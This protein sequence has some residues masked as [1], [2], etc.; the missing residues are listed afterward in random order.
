MSGAIAVR[1][2]S[3][4][5]ATI[6]ELD[7]SLIPHGHREGHLIF[8]LDGASASVNASGNDYTVDVDSAVAVSPWEPHSFNIDS[9]INGP[10]L[11]L[12]LYIKPIWFL[13]TSQRAEFSLSFGRSDIIM[14]DQIRQWVH[15]LTGQMLNEESD[16]LFNGYLFEITSQCYQQSWSGRRR[17]SVLNSMR[18]RFS[19]YRV[20]RS[21]QLMQDNFTTTMEMDSLAR[22]VGLSRPHFFKL[23]KKQMGVTPN[24]YLNTLRSEK[25]IE[26][27]MTT[28][29]T[30]S[31]IGFDLGF[32]SQ[33]SFTRFFASNV[34]IPPS[35][36]RRV[37]NAGT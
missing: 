8:Y 16:S 15:R 3:F 23:F 20:R 10:M 32:S 28:E 13:E 9:S 24:L 1:H 17:S 19:D 14:T 34:G 29:K 7:K 6:Y 27:L 2:G 18:S 21:L 4:G 12:T 35:D 5:R 30:V 31:D 25:A 37:A 22:E 11:C 26:F 36:Y 33:A